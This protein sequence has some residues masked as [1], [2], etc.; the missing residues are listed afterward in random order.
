MTAIVVNY[1]REKTSDAGVAVAYCSYMQREHVQE[2]VLAGL[3]RQLV[4]Q[5]HCSSEKVQTLFAAC[6]RAVRLPTFDELSSLLQHVAGTYPRVFIVIDALD[7]CP[8]ADFLALVTESVRLQEL[9]P[10]VQ[11]LATFRPH[12]TFD[13]SNADSDELEIRASDSDLEHYLKCNISRLSRRVEETPLLK[14]AVV[15][16]IIEAADGM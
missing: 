4:K 8:S 10:T 11:F 3:L 16:G 13:N 1:L 15:Q 9:L 12:L 6:Q 5:Q 7:E 14:E 2:K